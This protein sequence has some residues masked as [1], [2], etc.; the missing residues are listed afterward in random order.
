MF[1]RFHAFAHI[2][3]HAEFFM[4]FPLETFRKR[5]AGLTFAT[6]KFPQAS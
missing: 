1:Q 4:Q 3:E 5:F 6:R 2:H